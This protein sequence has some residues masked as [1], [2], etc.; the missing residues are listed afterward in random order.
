VT[1]VHRRRFARMAAAA[2]LGL[3][4]A[5]LWNI[6]RRDDDSLSADATAALA[7]LFERVVVAPGDDPSA[8]PLPVE[9]AHLIEIDRTGALLVHSG[10]RVTRH[11]KPRAYQEIDGRRHEVSVR[12]DLAATGNPRLAVGPYDRSFPLVIDSQ[13]GKDDRQP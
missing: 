4:V 9:N 1:T 11:Q 6:S 10:P 3:G 12:F 13:P 2:A 7:P 5:A 8:I